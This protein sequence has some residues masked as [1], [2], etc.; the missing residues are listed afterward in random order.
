V[1]HGRAPSLRIEELQALAT[2]DATGQPH[3]LRQQQCLLFQS[4]LL[5]RDS[6]LRQLRP[7]HVTEQSIAGLGPVPVLE[8]YQKKMGDE[9]RL[10]LPP[11][12]ATI[13]AAWGRA[14]RY[15]A[16]AAQRLSKGTGRVRRP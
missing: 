3:L 9:V 1:R 4:L 5:L 14:A 8:F 10:P 7:Y 16:A 15:L 6:D 11:R 12:A 2:C 13:W